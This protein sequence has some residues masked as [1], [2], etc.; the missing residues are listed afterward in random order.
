[1]KEET[2]AKPYYVICGTCM[3]ESCL[4][5]SLCKDFLLQKKMTESTYLNML[6]VDSVMKVNSLTN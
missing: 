5:D 3:S 4:S 6:K 2:E 1:M